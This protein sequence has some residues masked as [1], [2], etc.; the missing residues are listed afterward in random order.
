MAQLGTRWVRG[1][2]PQ[3]VTEYPASLSRKGNHFDGSEGYGAE[4]TAG[5]KGRFFEVVPPGGERF[6]PLLGARL[7]LE[8]PFRPVFELGAVPA[9]VVGE[10]L[11]ADEAIGP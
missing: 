6:S 1:S 10:L 11:V 4:E 9:H 8:E 7:V 2:K 5:E 3:L